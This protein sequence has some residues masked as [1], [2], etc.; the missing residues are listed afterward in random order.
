MLGKVELHCWDRED[1]IINISLGDR[2]TAVALIRRSHATFGGYK[3]HIC[4]LKHLNRFCTKE[5]RYRS[6]QRRFFF[7]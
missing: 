2:V 5:N 7:Y 1:N 3:C 6:K 4:L